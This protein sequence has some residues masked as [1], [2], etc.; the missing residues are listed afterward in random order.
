MIANY[1]RGIFA[2]TMTAAMLTAAGSAA[3][4]EARPAKDYNQRALEIYE[5]R[6][7]AQSGP[8]R[9]REIYYYKCWFCHNEFVKDVPHVQGLYQKPNMLSGLPVN[10]A[11]VKAKLRDGGPNMP[12]YKYAL[13][14]ADF[15]D[16]VSFL[17]EKCCWDSDSPPPNPRYIAK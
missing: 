17:R 3:A 13:K 1:A 8:E 10:D 7:A 14:D 16:L 5:F 6:K 15:D 9:G 12:A 2:A 4:E 11:N